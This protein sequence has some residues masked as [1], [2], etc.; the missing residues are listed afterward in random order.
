MP[1][2][3]RE[4]ICLPLGMQNTGCDD[5]INIVSNL[6]SG[7]SYWEKPIHV[8][9]AVFHLPVGGIWFI[10]D[11]RGFV[12]LGTGA[13]IDLGSS[14]KESTEKMFTAYKNDYACGWGHIE[15]Y[16]QKVQSS[17]RGH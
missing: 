16:G 17:F 13:E 1:K 3:I 5:G 10:F 14:G 15:N 2:Y 9:Y 6:A 11:D 8:T 4:N 12:S 7:Y